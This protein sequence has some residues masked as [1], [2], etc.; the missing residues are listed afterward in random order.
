[1]TPHE[2]R[3]CNW[4]KVLKELDPNLSSDSEAFKAGLIL[5]AALDVGT[6]VGAI[7]GATELPLTTVR[8][9]C[10]NLRS[11]GV[12]KGGKIYCE[13]DDEKSGGIA[14]WMDVAVANGLIQRAP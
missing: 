5:L 2:K 6:S 11:S 4:K 7:R 12:F 13:W 14:F 9:A 3:L 8:L 10:R 1:M